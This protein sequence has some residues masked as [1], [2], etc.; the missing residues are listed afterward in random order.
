MVEA[1]ICDFTRPPVGRYAGALKD[2]RTDDLAAAPIE[3]V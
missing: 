1:Y 3:R 2:V